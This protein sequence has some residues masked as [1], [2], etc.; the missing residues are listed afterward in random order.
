[1]SLE[2]V[3]LGQVVSLGGG[4][5]ALTYL[6][7]RPG[8]DVVVKL[9][10]RGLEAEAT[11]LRAWREHTSWIP[12]V[13]GAGMV[14][15]SGTPPLKYL[16]LGALVDDQGGV[17][18]TAAQ[19]LE[20]SPAR[21][22]QIGRELG[23]E[24]HKLH[25]ARCADGFGNFADS[26]GAERSYTTWRSYLE[27]FFMQHAGFVRGLGAPDRQIDHARAFIQQC[28]YVDE[29]RYLHGDVSIRNIAVHSADPVRISLFDPNP[30]GGDPSWDI[31]P[32][33]NNVEF[34]E[35]RYG[36]GGG[37][38]TLARDRE[39]LDG[40]W[41]SYPHVVAEESLLTAQLVQAVLQAEHRQDSADAPGVDDLDVQ[42]THEF[43][44]DALDRMSA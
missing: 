20:R 24:L 29:A 5:D 17:V 12:E 42:V 31:A 34:N 4:G 21:A 25:Q 13:L 33:T 14:P 43:I 9:N 40:F 32:M 26:P 30:L 23:G 37:S 18:E 16:V 3:S 19:Q 2:E 44:R 11:A 7:R 36:A 10:D 38:D 22:R 8:R 35:R 6:V 27:E 15:S 28:Q 39:L 41:E 1:M